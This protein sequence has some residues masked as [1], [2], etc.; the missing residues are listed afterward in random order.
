MTTADIVTRADPGQLAS[1]D[2][3]LDIE[4]RHYAIPYFYSM[5]DQYDALGGGV[6]YAQWRRKNVSASINQGDTSFALPPDFWEMKFISFGQSASGSQNLSFETGELQYIGEDAAQVAQ[7]EN[8]TT[9]IGRP[10]GY[11]FGGNPGAMTLKLSG[12]ADQGYTCRYSYYNG[13]V[14]AD[15]TSTVDLAAYIPE[16]YQWALVELLRRRLYGFRFGIGDTR[17]TWADQ[18]TKSIL[19]AA[20]KSLE[21][22]NQGKRARFAN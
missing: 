11:Y 18:E 4:L 15:D 10:T 17:F 8:A 6:G 13:I 1:P 7:A 20:R 3:N 14:F 12:P 21:Q 22:S 19:A 5:P 9:I 16:R 2:L